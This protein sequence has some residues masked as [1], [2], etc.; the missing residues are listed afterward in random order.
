MEARRLRASP[1]SGLVALLVAAAGVLAF[2]GTKGDADGQN[3]RLLRDQTA[4]ASLIATSTFD[5]YTSQVIGPLATA[6]ALNPTALQPTTVAIAAVARS[7]QLVVD[8]FRRS[9]N[10]FLA[11]AAAGPSQRIGEVASGSLAEVLDTARSAPRPPVAIFPQ[12]VPTP[13]VRQGSRSTVGF[14]QATAAGSDLVVYFQF[15]IDPFTYA[16]QLVKSGGPF[17]LLRAVL[18]G[19]SRPE[20]SSIVVAT[21]HQLPLRGSLA[22]T[23][24]QVGA[25]KWLLVTQART[26][27]AGGF[28]NA[29]PWVILFL[30]LFL[31]LVLGATVEVLVRRERYAARLVEERSA[32]VVAS[33]Q[34]LA[35]DERLSAL[36]KMATVIGHDLRNPLGAA[37][38]GVFLVRQRLANRPDPKLDGYVSM[39]EGAIGRATALADD[40]MAYVREREP[41][42]ASL[43]LRRVLTEVLESTPPPPGVEVSVD[44]DSVTVQADPTQLARILSNLVTNAYQAMPEGGVLRVTGSTYDG[45]DVITLHDSGEGFAPDIADRLFEPFITTKAEGTGLGLAIVQRLVDAH[46]GSIS[47]ENGSDGGALVTVRLPCGTSRS[48]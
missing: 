23:S 2:L 26:P 10:A 27:L 25:S 16:S 28:A 42:I 30:G 39:I 4:Q 18:Y 34:A 47:T 9:G 14:A 41:E 46:H 29:A 3:R 40:L 13:V 7:A 6:A 31:A 44:A 19:S 35:R 22:R 37:I 32:E 17:E 5:G 45:F 43:D 33:Q 8:V 48:R 1:L 15:T 21:T 38:N 11:I 12:Y 24:L 36:G 20:A